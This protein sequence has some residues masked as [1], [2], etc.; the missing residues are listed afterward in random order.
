MA[1]ETTTTPLLGPGSPMNAWAARYL[2]LYLADRLFGVTVMDDDGR[3][4]TEDKKRAVV[5]RVL[6]EQ[7]T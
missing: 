7:D 2:S 3:E 4:M 6:D 1:K 5:A